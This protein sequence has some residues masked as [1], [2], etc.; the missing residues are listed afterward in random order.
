MIWTFY[1]QLNN[2]YFFSVPIYG[3][4]HRYSAWAGPEVTKLVANYNQG[5]TVFAIIVAAKAFS[6]CTLYII[7]K[8][9][10]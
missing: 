1:D 5:S 9:E 10:L 4:C 3:P 8:A 7:S 6:M 2:F